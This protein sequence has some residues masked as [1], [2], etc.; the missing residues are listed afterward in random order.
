MQLRSRK[1]TLAGMLICVGILVG[2]L[3][4]FIVI[5]ISVPG[6]KIGLSNIVSVIALYLFG[7]SFAAIILLG[8]VILSGLL[9]G[10]GISIVY[11]ITGAVFSLLGMV[12]LYKI[13]S[14][15]VFGVSLTGGVIHN[16]AQLF[17]AYLFIQNTYIFY[18]IPV[19]IISGV[20]SGLLIGFLSN[21]LI[22]RFKN[23]NM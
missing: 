10:S 3:E 12:L 22:K 21:L 2:Y 13:K 9:F 23:I 15:S 5:P 17:V 18:Y 14:F 11:S 8:R 6:I 4:S 19:L 7:P 1:I 20:L 16:I